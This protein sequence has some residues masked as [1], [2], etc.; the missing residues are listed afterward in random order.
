VTDQLHLV[1]V[2]AA[3]LGVVALLL[4]LITIYNSLVASRRYADREWANVDVL[5]T[6]R[7]D[8]LPKLV[9]LCKKYMQYEE[10]ALAELT[11]ARAAWMGAR[12]VEAKASASRASTAGLRSLHAVAE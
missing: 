3:G 10:V 12:D 9:E 6:Q 7:F 8:E 5:L 4:Y 1:V 2:S 11:S